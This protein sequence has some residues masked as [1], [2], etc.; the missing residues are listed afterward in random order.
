MKLRRR[1]TAVS[2]STKTSPGGTSRKYAPPVDH[3]LSSKNAVVG[4]HRGAAAT[5]LLALLGCLCCSTRAKSPAVAAPSVAPPQTVAHFFDA[6]GKP[7]AAPGADG[8]Q[9]AVTT[10]QGEFVSEPNW[11]GLGPVTSTTTKPLP[12]VDGATYYQLV[13]AISKTKGASPATR[14]SGV[15]VH[16]VAASSGDAGGLAPAGTHPQVDAAGQSDGGVG[17]GSASSS[18][19]SCEVGARGRGPVRALGC[20]LVALLAWLRRRAYPLRHGTRA[21]PAWVRRATSARA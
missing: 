10:A 2:R 1:P 5:S 12:L 21:A 4:R 17:T 6:D 20:L 11:I 14:S 13:R 9:L 16:V 18:G 8:Y 3:D 15:V 7:I 19:C